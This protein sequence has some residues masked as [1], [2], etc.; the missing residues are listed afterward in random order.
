[1]VITVLNAYSGFALV[2]E[3]IFAWQTSNTSSLNTS[4]RLHAG[5]L[6]AHF[7]R[8]SDRC[9]R[10]YPVLHHGVYSIPVRLVQ[11]RTLTDV[12]V[13][14]S[15]LQ[16]VA[17]NRTLTNVLFGGIGTVAQSDYKIEG[18]ITKTSVDETVDALSNADSV[19]LVRHTCH[20][21]V[22]QIILTSFFSPMSGRWLW[23]GSCESAVRYF[24]NRQPVEVKGHQRPVRDPPCGG[25]VRRPLLNFFPSVLGPLNVLIHFS[26]MPGQCNVLLAEASVPYDSMFHAS[27]MSG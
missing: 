27:L 4:Y 23:D 7:C 9:Q 22:L 26:R 25:Q 11:F 14:V 13:Y 24:G 21:S 8:C 1:M 18:T 16:C 5:Q 10:L 15:V 2:A 20:L 3:G 17:M 19:I 12:G 6:P